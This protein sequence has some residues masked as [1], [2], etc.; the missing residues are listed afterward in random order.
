MSY[1]IDLKKI[2]IDNYKEILKT[3]NLIPSWMVLKENI[4]TNL[5]LMKKHNFQNL[6]ELLSALKNKSRLQ[7]LSRQSG[8][9][10]NYLSVLKRVINGYQPKPNRIKDFPNIS[11]VVAAKLEDLKLRN[12][13]KLYEEIRSPEKRKELSEKTG[14]TEDEMM[15]VTKLTDLSRIRWV[16]HT[17]AYVLMEAGYDT[18]QKVA[19][20][21]YQEM[22]ETIKQLNRERKIYN[23]HIGVNDMQMVVEAAKTLDFDIE[24]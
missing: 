9:S 16:N 15:K 18:A 10:E 19:G 8:L 21:D 17:F 3:A 5:D 22:Y 23:A 1:Y 20:A 7:E 4:D 13:L 12:T 6:D 2:S 24:Y 14:I 11:E